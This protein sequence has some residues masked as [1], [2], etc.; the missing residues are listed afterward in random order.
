[1]ADGRELKLFS[2]GSIVIGEYGWTPS[3]TMLDSIKEDLKYV[4]KCGLDSDPTGFLEHFKTAQRLIQEYIQEI[5]EILAESQVD[6]PNKIDREKLINDICTVERNFQYLTEYGRALVQ[7]HYETLRAHC[8]GGDP[9]DQELVQRELQVIWDEIGSL[10]ENI[11]Q[12]PYEEEITNVLI[13]RHL[14]GLEEEQS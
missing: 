13:L 8:N 4:R 2:D 1:L 6:Q 14:A 7:P 12:E 10:A 11:V 3:E 5:E 9:I